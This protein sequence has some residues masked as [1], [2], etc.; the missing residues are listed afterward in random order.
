MLTGK[1]ALSNFLRKF[2]WRDFL[3]VSALMLFD[4]AI[5]PL[6]GGPDRLNHDPA[7]YRLGDPN[8][9]PGDWYTDMS[10]ASR[11]YIFY[12][13]LVNA[14]YLVGLPEEFWRL[15]LY[16]VSLGLLYYSIIAIARLFSKSYFVIPVIAL[17]VSKIYHPEWL[18][19]PF[20]QI[21]GGLA[22]RSIGV[23]LSFFALY[24]FLKDR[25]LV[26][27]AILGV[28]TLI[29][30]SNSLIVFSLFLLVWLGKTVWD[31][32][33][34][35]QA[36]WRPQITS[37]LK[38]VGAYLLLGGWFA[39][40]VAAQGEHS[41]AFSA[42][43]FVWI[44]T[45]FRAPY[46]ALPLV[47]SG[48][49]RTFFLH[50]LVIPVGWTVL[51]R[52]LEPLGRRALDLLALVALAAVVYFFLFYLFAFVHPWLLGFQFYSLRVI[53]FTY[54]VAYLFFSIMV[55]D[56]IGQ[57]GDRVTKLFKLNRRFISATGLV[58]LLVA[59]PL[60]STRVYGPLFPEKV[61]TNLRSSW[62]WTTA[63][64]A[65]N[66]TSSD[67]ASP[68]IAWL[69]TKPEPFIAPPEWISTPH[70]QSNV[71][72]FQTSLYLPQAISYKSFGFTAAGLPE[73][74]A[75]INDL[76][77][78]V[79]EDTYQEQQK[80]GRKKPVVIDWGTIYSNLTAEN[81]EQL[82]QRYHFDLFV[83]TKATHYPFQILA[84]DDQFI[85]YRISGR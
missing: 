42:E 21:D 82:A 3:L 14:W 49:W 5:H 65:G 25:F 34:N 51:R 62:Q 19:G 69:V 56:G 2:P 15:F 1:E 32:R 22:P 66:P 75:R 44:W 71:R 61:R 23:S 40:Y 20:L 29:H 48:A 4:F 54:F 83:G 31:N 57:V 47:P 26:W 13:K 77:G 28:A 76:S 67:G 68:V 36:A 70:Y 46:M 58:I 43:K 39:A 85:L 8:Y 10:V 53:Y 33:G 30:A 73:W 17:L 12:A 84:T 81:V 37:A 60:F 72:K 74:Y 11:V 35:L 64:L 9:L 24:Y 41:T 80:T 45:Y 7:V 6:G 63:S 55:C 27:A 18:Y 38:I 52:K 16:V 59:V 78:G 79:I 50:I